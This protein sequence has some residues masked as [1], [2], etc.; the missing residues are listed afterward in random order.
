[1]KAAIL[2]C[3]RESTDYVSGQELCKRFG[4]SRTAV[5]KAINSLKEEGY[6][7]EAVPHRGYHLLASSGDVVSQEIYGENELR[8]RLHTSWAGQHLLYYPTIDS[9]NSKAKQ[10][11][12]AGAPHGTV[13]VA[14]HQTSGRGRRGREWDSPP[15][16]NL[17]FSLLL[18]PD[19][20][21]DRAS[22]LTLVISLSVAHAISELTHLDVRIK[23][24]N[25]II[26][27][28][29]KICG[30]LT[31]MSTELDFIH[32]VIIGVGINVG[33]QDFP[34]DLLLKA[35]SLERESNQGDAPFEISRSL[36]LASILT[37]FEQDY[38]LFLS[39]QGGGLAF[40]I[41]SYTELCQNC[42]E[43]V[44]V[45]DPAGAYNGI[46]RGINASG[47]LLVELP[48]GTI[49]QVYAGE[50]SVRGIYG[51]TNEDRSRA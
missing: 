12:E 11:A 37:H 19:F 18:K 35:T 29:K 49:R 9:T 4:V 39:D 48:D 45:L 36:L 46:A 38:A 17:Y 44:R 7:I 24:P 41:Q 28:G 30:I 6:P 20:P 34:D 40:L 8:S 25:D 2:S 16:K 14:D 22:M 1:M 42:N 50:V 13:I 33:K 15:G 5:W 3:L 31:E 47:E 26:L 10:E 51:Y 23:W 27:H 21:P 32:Y 43:E